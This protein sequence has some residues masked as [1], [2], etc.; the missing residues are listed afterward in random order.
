MMTIFAPSNDAF[1]H[2]RENP[3][4]KNLTHNMMVKVLGRLFV[5]QRKLM[6]TEVRNEMMLDTASQEKLRLNIYPKVYTNFKFGG[7]FSDLFLFNYQSVVIVGENCQWYPGHDG[8]Q[9]SI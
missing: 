4:T 5:L 8:A 2:L 3:W 9:C 6:P 7:T 1:L